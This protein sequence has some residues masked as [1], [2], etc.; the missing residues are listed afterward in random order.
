MLTEMNNQNSQP[1]LSVITA[2]HDQLEYNKIFWEMLSRYTF[3]RFELIAVDNASTDG[4]GNFFRKV[5]ATVITQTR[6]CNYSEAMNIG[7][8]KAKGDIICHINNDVIVGPAWDRI[9]S[10]AIDEYNFDF[11]SPASME[12][13][14]TYTETK[15]QLTIWKNICVSEA[16]SSREGIITTW[17]NMYH[18]WEMFCAQHEKK[19]RGKLLNAING[20]TVM[21]RRSAW[22][23]LGGYDE[24]MLAT[25]WDL[26]LR[27]KKREDIVGDIYAPRVVMWAYVHH[28]MGITSR[29]TKCAYD[30]KLK[31]YESIAQKWPTED[32]KKYWP[33]PMHLTPSPNLKTEPW[34]YLKYAFKRWLNL[35]QWGDN[36]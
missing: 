28:F 1:Q 3:H 11:V 10:A 15:K 4:S 19:N 31:P 16:P 20:H 35:Y 32:L 17:K 22:K 13:M 2:F 30:C 14:P 21:M 33:F 34:A 7:T 9:L 25:D 8:R 24:R 6:N 27:T 12:L 26:Y 29:V 18:N 36:W 5:G 23:K